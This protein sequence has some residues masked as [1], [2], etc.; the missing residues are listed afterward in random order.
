M[1]KETWL[2]MILSELPL[3]E[4]RENDFCNLILS[5]LQELRSMSFAKTQY[6]RYQLT[7]LGKLVNQS[8]LNP[9]SADR[10]LKCLIAIKNNMGNFEE[11]DFEGCILNAVGLAFEMRVSPF[12]RPRKTNSES[13]AKL[14]KQLARF[15]IFHDKHSTLLAGVLQ[16]WTKGHAIDE[17]IKEFNLN[18][19]DQGLLE[20]IVPKNALWILHSI[21]SLAQ[22]L[23]YPSALMSKIKDIETYIQAGTDSKV[24][25]DLISMQIPAL[26]R[27]SALFITERFHPV[28]VSALK[29]IRELDF[30]KEFPG[31]EDLSAK[32][33]K[34]IIQ[35][36]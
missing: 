8:M 30:K 17:I 4:N 31:K 9:L 3:M 14:R 12:D 5:E 34:D 18:A 6:G 33:L 11:S 24:A 22:M 25:A 29:E 21:R 2:W 16:S 15:G 20:E 19:S 13:V 10:I 35:K 27:S 32:I 7:A 28:D 26:G 1:L 23:G 36:V